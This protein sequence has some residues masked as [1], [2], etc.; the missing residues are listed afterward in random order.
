MTRRHNG[1]TAS[2]TIAATIIEMLAIAPS[3]LPHS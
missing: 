1:M 2:V 3:T